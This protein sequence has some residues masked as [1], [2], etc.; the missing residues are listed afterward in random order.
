MFCLGCEGHIGQLLPESLRLEESEVTTC[1]R[2]LCFCLLH[3]S[4]TATRSGQGP[5]AWTASQ[6]K[7]GSLT[8]GPVY[9]I[10]SPS[11]SMRCK[12]PYLMT[13]A[14]DEGWVKLLDSLGYAM[15]ASPHAFWQQ[16]GSRTRP[17]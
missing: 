8:P 1:F 2:F 16:L 12:P 14:L 6:S 9:N 10:I 15:V 11:W 13:I 4:I 3:G 7:A 5:S 17:I